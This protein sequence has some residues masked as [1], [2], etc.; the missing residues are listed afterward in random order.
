MAVISLTSPPAHNPKCHK[1]YE[2]MK[3]QTIAI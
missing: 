3:I 2:N 1:I